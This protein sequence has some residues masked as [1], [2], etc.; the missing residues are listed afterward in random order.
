MARADAVA[1]IF[2]ALKFLDGGLLDLADHAAERD[3]AVESYIGP[4]DRLDGDESAG[5]PTLHVVGA[6]PP[7]PAVAHD[8]PGLEPVAGEMF[9]LA[10]IGRVHVAGEQEIQSVAAPAQMPDRVGAAGIDQR[11]VGV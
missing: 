8:P 5:E 4:G 3:V 11:K 10:G 9:L 2:D 1:G 6:E 7:D